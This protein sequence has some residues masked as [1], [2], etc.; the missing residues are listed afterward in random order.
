[1]STGESELNNGHIQIPELVKPDIS[2]YCTGLEQ[3]HR[4]IE[5]NQAC[6]SDMCIVYGTSDLSVAAWDGRAG[7]L[8]KKDEHGG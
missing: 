4:C 6:L 1:M 7:L 5:Q 8:T 3:N 2:V